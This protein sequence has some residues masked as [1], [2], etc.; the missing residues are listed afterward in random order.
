MES[1]STVQFL[2]NDVNTPAAGTSRKITEAC[3]AE[4]TARLPSRCVPLASVCFCA[5]EDVGEERGCSPRRLLDHRT[6]LANVVL[7]LLVVL[8]LHGD[9]LRDE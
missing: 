8:K 7:G 5:R 4:Q 6:W 9:S 3:V 1:R 2:G